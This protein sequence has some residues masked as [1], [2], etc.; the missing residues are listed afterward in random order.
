MSIES[1][2]P[3]TGYNL[4]YDAEAKVK[5]SDVYQMTVSFVKPKAYIQN[6]IKFSGL[7]FRLKGIPA[8]GINP[9]AD[10]HHARITADTDLMF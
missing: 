4:E 7:E 5:Q 2:S 8:G 3:I 6:D 9:F 1:E 10:D